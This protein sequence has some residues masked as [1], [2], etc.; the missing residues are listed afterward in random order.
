MEALREW[1]MAVLA[2]SFLVAAAQGLMPSGPVKEVGRLICGL[3]LFLAV[4]RPVVGLQYNTLEAMLRDTTE[5]MTQ[6]QEDLEE[7]NRQM[8][9]TFIEEET[10]AYIEDK[11][12]EL[13]LEFQAEVHWDWSGT[14]PVPS[15]VTVSGRLTDD[16]RQRLTQALTQEL[17]LE[18]EAIVYVTADEEAP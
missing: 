10:Q 6:E 2:A 15:G 17:G 11:R 5:Q 9:Q 16:Q 18:V 3:L 14:V 8:H 7:E 13:G 4:A 12:E 1:L